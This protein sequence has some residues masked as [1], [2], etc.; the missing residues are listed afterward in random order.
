M[1]L[2]DIEKTAHIYLCLFVDRQQVRKTRQDKTTLLHFCTSTVLTDLAP[3]VA[4]ANQGGPG[5]IKINEIRRK[6]KRRTTK[7]KLVLH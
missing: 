2:V 5:T 6:G 3:Q 1:I 4:E 7:E